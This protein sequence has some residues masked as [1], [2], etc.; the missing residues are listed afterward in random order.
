ML[1]VVC[2]MLK[3]AIE[4]TS[5]VYV[6]TKRSPKLTSATETYVPKQTCKLVEEY[7]ATRNDEQTARL[8]QR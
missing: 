6:R 8:I 2:T 5:S 7:K 3:E 1:K 4:K